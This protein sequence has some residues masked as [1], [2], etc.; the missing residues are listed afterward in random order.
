MNISFLVSINGSY[1]CSITIELIYLKKLMIRKVMTEKNVLSVTMYFLPLHFNHGFKLQ[2][3]CHDLN[4]LRINLS[5][6]GTT[7]V[8]G[9]DY[10]CIVNEISKSKAAHLRENVVLDYRG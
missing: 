10:L 5:E 7:T 8:K 3:G 2:N 1:K 4:I 9:V 6:I